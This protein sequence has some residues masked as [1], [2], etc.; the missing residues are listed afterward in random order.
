MNENLQSGK[1]PHKIG[2][3]IVRAWFDSVV[4]PLIRAL[5]IED[6]LLRDKDWTWRFRPAGLL[7][8]LSVAKHIDWE[9]QDNLE[10][11]LVL[12]PDMKDAID[13]HDARVAVLAE[14]CQQLHDAVKLSQPLRNR[15]EQLTSSKSLAEIG[16]D[17]L[18]ALFGAYPPPDHHA[19]LA[20][21]IVNHSSDLP[22]YYALAPFWNR[23][24]G[25]F[26][27]ILKCGEVRNYEEAVQ[28]A[29]GALLDSV[30]RLMGFLKERRAKLSLEYD[31]PYILTGK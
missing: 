31:V 16:V 1:E 3:C 6:S 18:E 26:R 9:V 2:P 12:N 5:K 30:D 13:E 25:V 17:K 29:G 28:Q 24:L 22:E 23:H 21:Y 8:L 27:E 11:F 19:L 14:K 7:S 15:Y 10:Q 20:Q 4:N